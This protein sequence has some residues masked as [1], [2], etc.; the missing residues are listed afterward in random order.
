MVRDDYDGRAEEF[1]PQEQAERE[2][3]AAERRR[4]EE[5]DRGPDWGE[6]CVYQRFDELGESGWRPFATRAEAEEY[7]AELRALLEEEIRT[8]PP[9]EVARRLAAAA[10][11]VEPRV[12][13]EAL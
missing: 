3:E 8:M 4:E 13:G 11:V 7:A 10:V 9:V 6:W 5:V 2:F 1:D 12:P